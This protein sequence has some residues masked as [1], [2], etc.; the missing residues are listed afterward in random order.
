MTTDQ[1]NPLANAITVP[2]VK[3]WKKLAI[4]SV[5]GG[6]AFALTLAIIVA[7][8]GWYSTRPK[9]SKP[10][11]INAIVAK[12]APS[13]DSSDDGKRIE[14]SYLLDNTTD[15]DYQLDSDNQ[16]RVMLRSKEQTFSSPI[17]KEDA[18]VTM[19]VFIPAKQKGMFVLWVTPPGIPMRDSGESPEA[20]HERLRAYLEQHL[21][22]TASFAVFDDNNR[23]QI[24]LPRW[25]SKPPPK[26]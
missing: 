3:W 17:P 26:N 5:I 23:F 19:P 1:L 20:Y 16:I 9:P 11:N 13:F 15:S 24:N 21:N 4:I 2:Q 12:G 14:L 6:V 10:W 18:S 22:G 25:L 7:L 8:A